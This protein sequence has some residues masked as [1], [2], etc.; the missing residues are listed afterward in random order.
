[1]KKFCEKSIFHPIIMKLTG[2]GERPMRKRTK[3]QN[4][5]QLEKLIYGEFIAYGQ[6]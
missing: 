5:E 3:C 1:L 4:H 6:F 2:I